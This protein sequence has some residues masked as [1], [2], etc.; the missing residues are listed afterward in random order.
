[1][2]TPGTSLGRHDFVQAEL[3]LMATDHQVLLDRILGARHARSV[4][5]AVTLRASEGQLYVEEDPS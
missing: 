1:M 3:E 5:V 4:I 2:K